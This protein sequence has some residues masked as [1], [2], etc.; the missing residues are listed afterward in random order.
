MPDETKPPHTRTS[1]AEKPVLD[2][3]RQV[4]RDTPVDARREQPPPATATDAEV[5]GFVERMRTIAPA[6]TTGRGRLVFAMDAT[7][8]REPT[9]D[10]ALGLQADM[11]KA[12][13]AVGGLDVQLVYYRGAGECRASRWVSDTDTLASLMTKVACQGGYTQ[14][15]R[16]LAH[17]RSETEIQRVSAA[18]VVGDAFEEKIDDVCAR[19]GEVGL[20]GVPLFMFQEGTD[21]PTTRAYRE[22]ARLT[23][24]A[25]CSFDHGSADQ[26]RALLSAVAVY[27]AGGHRAL[28]RL[29]LGRDG[30]SARR[31]IEQMRN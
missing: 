24:G 31:M 1:S 9:W 15:G 2:A 27:A 16:V 8:S 30:A 29:A 10:L 20:L 7:M 14:I 13:K 23:K 5:A 25:H 17:I 12:V 19:A 26:L 28:E 3:T 18:V 6:T 11:F 21:T 4:R 22:I